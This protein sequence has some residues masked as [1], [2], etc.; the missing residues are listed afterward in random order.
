MFEITTPAGQPI[1]VPDAELELQGDTLDPKPE[2]PTETFREFRER[3][4]LS[5]R[6]VQEGTALAGSVIWRAEQDG[7]TVT[8]EQRTA[9]WDYL[10]N[11]EGE[12]PSGK[13]VTV[14][15]G[16]Q[17][18]VVKPGKSDQ[19][20][21]LEQTQQQLVAMTT[22]RNTLLG[23]FTEVEALVLAAIDKAILAK[24]ST[25]SLKEIHALLANPYG[26]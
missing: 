1:L 11:F 4:G 17:P 15:K 9:I 21:L 14:K 24:A 2:T 7:K 5:R 20:E 3:L 10:V 19:S 12:F 13:P 26:A 22:E 18:K 16:K 25:K 6:E 8:P 23:V